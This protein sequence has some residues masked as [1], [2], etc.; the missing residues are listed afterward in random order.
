[1][2]LAFKKKTLFG[3]Q[4]WRPW[5]DVSTK[6]MLSIKLSDQSEACHRHDTWM[7][8]RISSYVQ[9]SPWQFTRKSLSWRM[10][11]PNMPRDVLSMPVPL[12][13]M[14]AAA[15]ASDIC[16]WLSE[17]CCLLLMNSPKSETFLVSKS[18]TQ[19]P[20]AMDY[21]EAFWQSSSGDNCVRES[22]PWWNSTLFK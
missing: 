4:I 5:E 7:M 9:C 20:T 22:M 21:P 2:D 1:M 8:L 12:V 13:T 3:P 17:S 14:L 11:T 19:P 16:L 18:E 15:M 10:P 6:Q